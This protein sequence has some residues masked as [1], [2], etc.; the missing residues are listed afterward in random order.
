MLRRNSCSARIRST[1]RQKPQTT[2]RVAAL[3]WTQ[4]HLGLA[5][6]GKPPAGTQGL[7][8]TALSAVEHELAPHPTAHQLLSDSESITYL[9]IVEKT[10][11]VLQPVSGQTLY[12]WTSLLLLLEASV[13]WKL[14]GNRL[15]LFDVQQ[16]RPN[17][18]AS[19]ICK[20]LPVWNSS[21]VQEDSN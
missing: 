8:T 11:S 4:W 17:T 9:T 12:I 10:G 7:Q 20:Q 18:V 15:Q 2:V 5:S 13:A 16:I 21:A 6:K 1:K 14:E 19:V 3:F